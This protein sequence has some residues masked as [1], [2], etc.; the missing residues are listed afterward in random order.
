MEG[1]ALCENGGAN[2]LH[3]GLV[4]LGEVVADVLHQPL[5]TGLAGLTLVVLAGLTSPHLERLVRS[6]HRAV[7][8]GE[9]L[10]LD[11]RAVGAGATE[12][13]LVT[14]VV[15]LTVVGLEVAQATKP[16]GRL[17]LHHL[18]T[19][20]GSLHG[21]TREERERRTV[22]VVIKTDLLV[23][24]AQSVV[25]VLVL[26]RLAGL[27][28]AEHRVGDHT[29][30]ARWNRHHTLRRQLNLFMF[31]KCVDQRTVLN[32]RN[33]AVGVQDVDVVPR[34]DADDLRHGSVLCSRT[35]TSDLKQS[36]EKKEKQ[37]LHTQGK[38]L[39][40]SLEC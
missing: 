4:H 33:T 23:T 11:A 26:Q 14:G 21:L 22:K 40:R 20:H 8:H 18:Q 10:H 12:Q 29:V 38:K 39:F 31:L 25:A 1:L 2:D 7:D 35:Q 16:K 5:L 32:T 13:P 17:R 34:R 28:V 3:H 36:A 19:F 9:H 37:T 30:V 27:R 6:D 15:L 24:T